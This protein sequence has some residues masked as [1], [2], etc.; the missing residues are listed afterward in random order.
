MNDYNSLISLI[1]ARIAQK[2]KS[3]L[4]VKVSETIKQ[5]IQQKM[6]VG[7]DFL[8]TERELSEMLSISR[9]TVRKALDVLDKDQVVVRS[10][11]CGTMVSDTLEYSLKEPKGFSQQV[12]LKGKRPDTLWIKKEIVAS[13]A[14]IAEQ[15]N[16]SVNDEV[17]LLK[18][19]RYVDDQ[20]VSIEESYVPAHLIADAD[21]IQVSLYEYFRSQ[22]IILTR[23]KSRVSAQMPTDEF[24]EHLGLKSTVP[25]LVIK[26]VAFDISG[27]LMEYS[28]NYC[29][30][31]MYV[32][33]AED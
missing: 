28:V 23:T 31:D 25:V 9:I 15:L 24:L 30:G 16:I 18:R 14:D 20:P 32:F 22:N 17:F 11:G 33:V 6:L 3:P 27:Q 29:R 8:P 19:I 12:V 2:D 5:A 13:N 10:R 26:Q 7:G 21:D 1:K 4:Y